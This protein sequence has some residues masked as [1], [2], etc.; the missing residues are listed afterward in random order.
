[1]DTIGNPNPA[2]TMTAGGSISRPSGGRL[3][4]LVPAT[5]ELRHSAMPAADRGAPGTRGGSFEHDLFGKPVLP[6][7]IMLRKIWSVHHLKAKAESALSQFAFGCITGRSGQP[8]D[9]RR[10]VLENAPEGRV[11]QGFVPSAVMAS[12]ASRN[13]RAP[14]RGPE[15]SRPVRSQGTSRHSPSGLHD[16]VP[17]AKGSWRASR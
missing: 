15:A 1:Q 6:F 4:A 13:C 12:E 10:V 16:G 14:G 3:P 11:P 9:S 5:S 7:G 17:L 2:V 8:V